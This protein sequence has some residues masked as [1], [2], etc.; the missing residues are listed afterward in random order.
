VIDFFAWFRSFSFDDQT[1]PILALA[2]CW[3]S[4]LKD[5]DPGIK[6]VTICF[7]DYERNNEMRHRY[8]DREA[9]K[10][11]AMKGKSE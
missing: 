9:K 4:I 6:S 3:N 8:Y 7:D 2:M 1:T 10:S 5:H 11:M